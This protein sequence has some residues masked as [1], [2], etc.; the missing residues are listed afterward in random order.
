M[1]HQQLISNHR[2]SLLIYAERSGSI[3]K[4]CKLFG[5]SRTTYYKLK[6]QYIKT[7]SLAPRVRRRPKMPNE[8]SLSKKK[9]LL[10]FV[11]QYPAWGPARYA[12]AFRQEG[13]SITQGCIWHHLKRFGLH[14]RYQRLIYLEA[15]K[16]KNRPL[17]E[18]T[19]R[20][21]KRQC[22]KAPQGLWPGHRVGLD[23][24]YVGHIKGVGRIYQLSGIDLCSRFGWA[25]LYL[26]KDKAAS[27]DFVENCLVP[28][29][30][31]NDV[32]LESIVTDN[33]TEFTAR[34][35]HKMLV[36]Y[37][38][39][40]VRIPKGKPMFN[41]CCERFQRTLHEEFYQHIFRIRFFRKLDE[42]QEELNRYLV[43]YNFKRIH[44]GAV[45]QGAVPIDIF[46]AKRSL[47][48]QRFQKL[49]T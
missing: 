18:R 7:G 17:T 49:L 10:R 30:F 8:A 32:Q 11:Q 40:H 6:E 16:D 26:N 28:K 45:K 42:L 39:A 36:D 25:K 29:F 23:T 34:G 48:R 22:L 37:D 33:G 5:V 41:G 46:K 14:R 2:K 19:L 20:I 47:L 9:L 1:T 3:A 43:Y 31:Y 24:F 35:F 15:L 44:F 38:I 21:V 4:A 12:Y 27:I 13:I